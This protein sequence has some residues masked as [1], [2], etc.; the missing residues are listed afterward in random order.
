MT[1]GDDL[2]LLQSLTYVPLEDESEYEV[3]TTTEVQPEKQHDLD[4]ETES[5]EDV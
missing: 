5:S 3:T 4:F 2:C 1:H